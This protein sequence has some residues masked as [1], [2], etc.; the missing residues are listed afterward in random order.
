[1]NLSSTASIV[2]LPAN[3]ASG[4][5]CGVIRSE[6]RRWRH[7][8]SLL[9][10]VVKSFSSRC[11]SLNWQN[12]ILRDCKILGKDSAGLSE[13]RPGANESEENSATPKDAPVRPSLARNQGNTSLALPSAPRLKITDRG[14]KP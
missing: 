11:H 8:T 3:G 7:E 10:R 6:R 2:G 9:T 13:R 1:M 14:A 4:A 12:K 5:E